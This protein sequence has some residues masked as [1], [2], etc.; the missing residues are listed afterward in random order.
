MEEDRAQSL[1]TIHPL[2]CIFLISESDQQQLIPML[3]IH[4]LYELNRKNLEDDK[5]LVIKNYFNSTFLTQKFFVLQMLF[6]NRR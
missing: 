6:E 2:I 3:L 5:Q 4:K 1:F